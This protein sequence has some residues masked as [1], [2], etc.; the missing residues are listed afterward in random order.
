MKRL[1]RYTILFAILCFEFSSSLLSQDAIY[2]LEIV[3]DS[4]KATQPQQ[5]SPVLRQPKSGKLAIA[6]SAALP[7]AGQVYA[8]RYYTIPIIWGC[9]AFFYS[10]YHKADSYYKDFREQYRLSVEQDTISHIG[11]TFYKSTRDYYHD[12]RDEFTLYLALTYILNIVDAYVGATL[13]DFDVSTQLNGGVTL[14]YR[15]PLR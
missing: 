14:R 5:V 10:Q 1:L 9:G 13:Y 7:G 4:I 3:S 8:K 2:H 6:L 15:I 12:K 11:N